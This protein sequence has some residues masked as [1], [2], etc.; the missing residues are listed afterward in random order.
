[1]RDAAAIAAA[2]G[3]K[4]VNNGWMVLCPCPSHR[5]TKP[6]CSIRD[7]GLITCF[8]GC[9]RK[10]VWAALDALGFVDDERPTTKVDKNKLERERHFKILYAQQDWF[11]IDDPNVPPTVNIPPTG[12][13]KNRGI[14]LPAPDCLR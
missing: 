12:Y 3:G 9:D 1:M 8:S 10:D 7:D 4:R 13:L 5:E 2:L 11:G 14:S 6:S